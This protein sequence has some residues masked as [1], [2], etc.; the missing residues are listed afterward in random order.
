MADLSSEMTQT[1]RVRN[2]IFKLQKNKSVNLGFFS[3]QQYLANAKPQR[4]YN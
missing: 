2:K 3:I 1:R 4:I